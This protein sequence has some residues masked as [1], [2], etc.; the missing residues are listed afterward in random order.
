MFLYIFL[1]PLC[2]QAQTAY[3][4]LIGFKNFKPQPFQYEYGLCPWQSF[5]Y[6]GTYTYQLDLV[7]DSVAMHVL[8]QDDHLF[9]EALKHI[10]NAYPLN[11]YNVELIRRWDS[12]PGKYKIHIPGLL[13]P[14]NKY[15]KIIRPGGAFSITKQGYDGWYYQA[16]QSGIAIAVKELGDNEFQV[17]ACIF[18]EAIVPQLSADELKEIQLAIDMA[19]IFVLNL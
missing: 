13:Q 19:K 11:I 3:H 5:R 18:L 16:H 12:S 2:L 6:I 9:E 1:F 8:Q 10:Y 15:Y 4:A 7:C 14:M 17:S